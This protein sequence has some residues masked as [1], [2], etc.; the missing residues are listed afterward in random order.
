M[1]YGLEVSWMIGLGNHSL[2]VQAIDAPSSAASAAGMVAAFKGVNLILM[3][4][5]LLLLLQYLRGECSG[6]QRTRLTRFLVLYYRRRTYRTWSCQDLVHPSLLFV[7]AIAFLSSF[8]LVDTARP[9]RSTA[10]G[11]YILWV[12]YPFRAKNCC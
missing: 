7:A 11:Q 3:T 4:S 1:L 5:R 12:R 8:L 9:Q 2:L 6:C 10:I